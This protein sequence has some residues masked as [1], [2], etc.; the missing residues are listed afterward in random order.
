MTEKEMVQKWEGIYQLHELTKKYIIIAEELDIHQNSFLQPINEQ[1]NAYE[2]VIRSMSNHYG[3]QDE[4]DDD[5][6]SMNLDKALGHEYRAYFDTLDW[7]SISLKER[8]QNILGE[9]SSDII[10]KAIPAYYSTYRIRINDIVTNIAG[11]RGSKDIGKD[12]DKLLI[13]VKEYK[14]VIEELIQ[15]YNSIADRQESMIELLNEKRNA[16]LEWQKDRTKERI[17][18]FVLGVVASGIIATLFFIIS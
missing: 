10:G 1:K 18:S 6:I 8:I 4:K 9:Y 16:E 2:H 14:E 15:I 11:I 13:T 17:I 5:Y 12:K 7:L 3:F